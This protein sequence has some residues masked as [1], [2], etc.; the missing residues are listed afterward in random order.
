MCDR[1]QIP[2]GPDVCTPKQTRENFILVKFSREREE[3]ER[4]KAQG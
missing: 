1:L 4:F 2:C 3:R